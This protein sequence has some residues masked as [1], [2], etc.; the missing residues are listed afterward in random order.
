M[1]LF[2]SLVVVVVVVDAHVVFA[3]YIFRLL[4]RVLFERGSV[5][6]TVVPQMISGNE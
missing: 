3:L 6:C 2:I 1:L 4:L 5:L